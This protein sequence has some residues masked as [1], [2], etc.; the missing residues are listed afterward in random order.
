MISCSIIVPTYNRPLCLKRILSYYNDYENTYNIIIADSSSDEDKEL[1]KNIIASVSN[2]AIQ[3]LDHYSIEINPHHKMADAVN[4]AKTKYCV[5]CA[6]DDFVTP[7]GI[8]Q[9][10]DFLEKNPDFIVAHGCYIGFRLESDKRKK[11]QFHWKSAYSHESITFSEAESRLSHH[12]SNYSQPTVYA[13]HRTELLKMVYEETLKAGVDPLFFGERLPSI[14]TLIYGKMKCLDVFYAAR[15]EE[16][17]SLSGY[18]PTL[19]DAIKAGIYDEE[20]A[21][22]RGCL[23]IHLSKQSQLDI[24]EARKVVDKA[25]YRY[26][27]YP[28][29]PL[30]IKMEAILGYLRLPAWIDKNIRALYRAL[31]LRKQRKQKPGPLIFPDISPS[32]KYYDDFNSIRLHVLAHSKI[33]LE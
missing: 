3:Y 4:Y 25:M 18:W 30:I 24:K 8:K 26:M 2:L 5:F 22:F 6:D 7:N 17:T 32:S 28:V 12:L 13:V 15:D 20:Y 11:Q 10:V 23:S 31:F 33:N 16:A 1:N 27:S 9:S 21:K 19:R 29:N 14:L